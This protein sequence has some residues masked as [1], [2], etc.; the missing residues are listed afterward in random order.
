MYVQD[1]ILGRETEELVPTGLTVAEVPDVACR[2]AKFTSCPHLHKLISQRYPACS[3]LLKLISLI[4]AITH[5]RIYLVRSHC[6]KYTM[7]R[8]G[9][10]LFYQNL[11]K[12]ISVDLSRFVESSAT[13]FSGEP[14]GGASER[15]PE[16]F[17]PV[18]DHVHPLTT[19]HTKSC[20]F[21]AIDSMI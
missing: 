7:Y 6:V 11:F 9:L 21:G 18:G 4:M 14:R 17:A 1:E 13:S 19:T 10:T 12:I 2:N 15:S 20:V 3:V 16:W 5:D 8:R